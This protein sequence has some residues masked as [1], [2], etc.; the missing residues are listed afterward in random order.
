M[1]RYLIYGI[2]G[3]VLLGVYM[4][5]ADGNKFGWDKVDMGLLA[6]RGIGAGFGGLVIGLGV[7]WVAGRAKPK[8]RP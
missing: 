4:F 7:A 3:F 5:I 8:N 6:A 2:V 1:K